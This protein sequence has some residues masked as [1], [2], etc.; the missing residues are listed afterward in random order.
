MKK[1]I[2]AVIMIFLLNGIVYAQSSNSQVKEKPLTPMTG[3]E[4]S[5]EQKVKWKA[6]N[7]EIKEKKEKAKA[8]TTDKKALAKK[9]KE[10]NEEHRIK[11]EEILTPEQREQY[12]KN[13]EEIQRMREKE[14][15]K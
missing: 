1:L 5:P 15:N 9:I 12:N 10:I 4:L 13:M 2:Q 11:R 8:E 14:R 6:L 3:I 7:E